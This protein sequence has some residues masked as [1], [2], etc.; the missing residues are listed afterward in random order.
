MSSIPASSLDPARPLRPAPFVPDYEVERL[1]G[2]GSYGTVWLAHSTLGTRRA[3]KVVYRDSFDSE[4][5]YLREFAGIRAYEPVSSHESQVRVFHVGKNDE[6]GYFYYVME[7]ADDAASLAKAAATSPAPESSAT[8][9]AYAPATL[10]VLLK[11]RGRLPGAEALPIARALAS[12]LDHL[13]GHGLVHRDIKPSNIILVGG[14]PKLADIGLVTSATNADTLVGTIGFIPPEGPGTPTADLYSFGK[15]LYEMVTGHDRQEFPNLPDDLPQLADRELLLEFN[16][17]ILKCCHQDPRGRYATAADLRADLQRIETGHSLRRDRARRR[18]M[19][20]A[21]CLAALGLV[22]ISLWQF[23][24]QLRP[25]S[26]AAAGEARPLPAARVTPA[27]PVPRWTNSLGMI[28]VS[29]PGLAAEFSIWET[30]VQDFRAFV[31]ESG[32]EPDHATFVVAGLKKSPKRPRK[33]DDPQSAPTPAHPVR[34]I[35]GTDAQA[36]CAWLTRREHQAGTL[37]T[38]RAYRLPRD[39]E[40]S[41]AAGLTNETGQT[42]IERF[43]SGGS[44]DLYYWGTNWPPPPTAGNFAGQ[45]APFAARLREYVDAFP[46]AGPVGSFPA[47][48]HGLFDMAGNLSE[49]CEEW[50]ATPLPPGQE[51]KFVVRGG[52]WDCYVPGCMLIR[53]RK[54]SELREAGVGWGFRVVCVPADDGGRQF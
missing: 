47:E 32:H 2:R 13:H 26:P 18:Q 21:A 4:R 8:P 34:A 37:A 45:E 15:V 19:L 6:A 35:S 52:S 1:I 39:V 31:E 27:A 16:E 11:Q 9:P 51:A 14:R 24:Q 42:S 17:I 10:G 33:W 7:L 36:F 44:A 41:W 12:A 50:P 5:P 29:V 40:W 48:S 22:A 53:S 43:A 46:V 28:F 30:R 3:V 20:A 23:V 38:N 54:Y 25:A 49:F